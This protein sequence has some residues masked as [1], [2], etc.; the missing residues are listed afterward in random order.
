MLVLHNT[1]QSAVTLDLSG[2]GVTELRAVIGVEDASLDGTSLK[3]GGQ[4]SVVIGN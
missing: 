2:L 1:T 4:T 3:L